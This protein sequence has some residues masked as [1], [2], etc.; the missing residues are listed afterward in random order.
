MATLLVIIYEYCKIVYLFR[1]FNLNTILNC[2]LSTN[3]NLKYILIY[4]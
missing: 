1:Y 4:P 3:N 2:N